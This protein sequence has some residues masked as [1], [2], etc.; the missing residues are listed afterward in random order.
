MFVKMHR[1]M[2]QK[3]SHLFSATASQWLRVSQLIIRERIDLSKSQNERLCCEEISWNELVWCLDGL[4]LH[5]SVA[6]AHACTHI[7]TQT[8]ASGLGDWRSFFLNMIWGFSLYLEI[9]WQ[10][11]A[12][13]VFFFYTFFFF[14]KKR[15]ISLIFRT[16]FA[17][18]SNCKN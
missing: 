4:C 1:I 15:D 14:W 12:S 6:H 7:H 9:S 8:T 2:T 13:C 11:W 3:T 5:F 16:L 18:S 17:V 10:Q